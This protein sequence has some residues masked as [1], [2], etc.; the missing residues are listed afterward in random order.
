MYYIHRGVRRFEPDLELCSLPMDCRVRTGTHIV[1]H[2]QLGYAC[3]CFLAG[4]LVVGL[5]SRMLE[6]RTVHTLRW[7]LVCTV[8]VVGVATSF[9][10]SGMHVHTW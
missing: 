8:G 3:T 5:S 1:S 4:L 6:L 2:G 9:D 10:K 7:S